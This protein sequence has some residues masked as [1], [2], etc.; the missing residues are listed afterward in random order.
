MM[1]HKN[2]VRNEE[3]YKPVAVHFNQDNHNMGD[4]TVMGI[5]TTSRNIVQR[6]ACE[7]AWIR[8]L[9]TTQPWGMNISM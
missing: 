7:S 6:L 3:L 4:F 5:C 9:S 2:D 1:Q 8:L